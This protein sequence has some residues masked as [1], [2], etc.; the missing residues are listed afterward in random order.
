MKIIA[1]DID[2]VLLPEKTHKL[3]HNIS[4]AKKIRGNKN[5]PIKSKRE[6][7]QA[8][9]ELV[10]FD[11]HAVMLIN[12]LAE[13]TGAKIILHT[14]WRRN[15][16]LEETKAKVIREGI[17]E[18]YLHE[19]CNLHYKMSSTKASDISLWIENHRV[20]P[21]PNV[22]S[23]HS[24]EL[25]NG[26]TY[27]IIDDECV[28]YDP[29]V[30]QVLPK[31]QDGFG[32]EEYRIACAMLNTEDADMDV[33]LLSDEELDKVKKHFGSPRKMYKWLYSLRSNSNY[34]VPRA[35]LISFEQ[36]KQ[37]LNKIKRLYHNDDETL[38]NLYLKRSRKTW[39][40]LDDIFRVNK[41]HHLIIYNL[42][43][44]VEITGV[45]FTSIKERPHN[46]PCIFI[47]NEDEPK[48]IY[49][50]DNVDNPYDFLF[51]YAQCLENI[52]K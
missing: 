42:E 13:K 9:S 24:C 31:Y 44:F 37:E 34:T 10:S 14:N 25:D 45:R 51:G 3:P 39:N 32:Y 11:P 35:S 12:Q 50:P 21:F 40:S 46:F 48:Y 8:Y 27:V 28:D 16:G 33:A 52:E 17:K 15:F 18:E 36:A 38:D 26:I 7:V 41:K 47:G 1:L 29:D 4:L 2:G 30:N 49:A 43:S 20:K 22:E 6:F 5:N 19:D 23:K